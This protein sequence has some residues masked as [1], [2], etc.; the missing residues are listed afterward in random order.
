MPA[1]PSANPNDPANQ[2]SG[3]PGVPNWLDPTYQIG[4]ILGGQGI[5]NP[6]P[7]TYT[8]VSSVPGG[9]LPSPNGV[10]AVGTSQNNTPYVVLATG[11]L[12]LNMGGFQQVYGPAAKVGPTGQTVQQLLSS[13]WSYA[14]IADMI[15]MSGQ[16]PQY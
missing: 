7:G 2:P 10:T 6:A 15:A 14:D 9:I 12:S 3:I 11:G 5:P 16:L 8:P 1:L 13:G 4:V